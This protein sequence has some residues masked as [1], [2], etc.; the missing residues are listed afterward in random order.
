[1]TPRGI[2]QLGGCFIAFCFI[3]MLAMYGG[4]FLWR[5]S[6]GGGGGG[7]PG[8]EGGEYPMGDAPPPPSKPKTRLEELHDLRFNPEKAVELCRKIIAD[9]TS[10][11]EGQSA[12]DKLPALLG[13]AFENRMQHG[14]YDAAEPY[15]RELRSDFPG[16]KEELEA[17]KRWLDYM[18]NLACRAIGE[19]DYAKAEPFIDQVVN[20]PDVPAPDFFLDPYQHFL[21]EKWR[22]SVK[23]GK[24]DDAKAYILA[25]TSINVGQNGAGNVANTLGQQAPPESLIPTGD[26]LAAKGDPGAALTFFLAAEYAAGRSGRLKLSPEDETS[27]DEK[28]NGCRL[29][30]ALRARAAGKLTGQASA[31]DFYR[32]VIGAQRIGQRLDAAQGLMEVRLDK[33][34]KALDEKNYAGAVEENRHLLGEE[35]CEVWALQC[36]KEGTDPFVDVTDE[37]LKAVQQVRP[38]GR[39]ARQSAHI[40]K[41]LT[42]AGRY[43]P[44][45]P[46]AESAWNALPEIQAKWG[47]SLLRSRTE[48]ALSR[49]RGL[50]REFPTH[51]TTASIRSAIQTE[52]REARA[53]GRFE[54]LVDLTSFYVSEIGPPE[55]KDLFRSE[56]FTCLKTASEHFKESEPMKRVFLLTLIADAFPGDPAAEPARKEAIEQ[57]MKIAGQHPAKP[58]EAPEMTGPSGLEGLSYHRVF[59]DTGYYLLVFYDGP[60][61]FF[62]RLAPYRHGCAVMKDGKYTLGVAV[63][64]ENVVPY[65]EDVAC[66]GQSFMSAYVIHTEGEAPKAGDLSWASLTGAFT[67]LRAPPGTGPF[68]VDAKSGEVKTPGR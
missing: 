36:E 45:L 58:N 50:L 5:P 28:I 53:A 62:A 3:S 11:A 25:A 48:D 30:L 24:E 4:V 44:P 51:P 19:K 66:T 12:K 64:V 65:R 61:K 6:P 31:E 26:E 14:K 33:A 29:A 35:A 54:A 38:K 42:R 63:T 9:P 55:S 34:R 39:E 57:A 18:A 56:L 21:V 27:L 32:G 2:K 7:Y 59:N 43:H 49:L 23:A 15:F 16:S 37:E 60:E 68:E 8:G 67:L 40:L 10:P 13:S 1:M 41:A 46:E 22:Q 47:V 52:I 17:R 20:D